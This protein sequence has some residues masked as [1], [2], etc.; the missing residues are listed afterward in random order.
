MQTTL[1]LTLCFELHVRRFGPFRFVN[2]AWRSTHVLG[3]RL[4]LLSSQLLSTLKQWFGVTP[5]I[6]PLHK[7]AKCCRWKGEGK[8]LANRRPN[9]K[10]TAYTNSMEHGKS[11]W[12]RADLFHWII[13]S[14]VFASRSMLFQILTLSLLLYQQHTPSSMIGIILN[15]YFKLDTYSINTHICAQTTCI[16]SIVF[17]YFVKVR[18]YH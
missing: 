12:K 17:L 2:Q 6:G 5:V 11:K 4:C 18:H 10:P 9:S 1:T 13:V 14:S 16:H 3:H 15:H 7:L 8:D